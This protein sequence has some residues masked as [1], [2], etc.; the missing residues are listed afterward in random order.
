MQLYGC[1]IYAA[2]R[3]HVKPSGRRVRDAG[4][5]A[6]GAKL[7]AADDWIRQAH[8]D[9]EGFWE[10][11]AFRLYEA[12][13]IVVRPG[14]RLELDEQPY[15]EVWLIRAGQ[16][17]IQLRGQRVVAGPGEVAV[18]R[19]GGHRVSANEGGEPLALVGFGFSVMMF[20]AVDLLPRLELPLV[21]SDPSGR[22]R[23][24]V[25]SVV[26]ATNGTRTDR[27]FR[28]RGQAEL[29]FAEIIGLAGID[30]PA[31]ASTEALRDEVEAALAYIAEHYPDR[32]DVTTL[33]SA[34]HLSPKY[35][36][37]CFREALGI[38]PMA[39]VRRY[40]L[41][42]AREQLVT[43][44]LPITRIAHD[45]GFQDAAHFS[46]AFR[47]LYGVSARILREHAR[48]LRSN[49]EY[50]GTSFPDSTTVT[51]GYQDT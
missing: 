41:E 14:W 7:P 20:E 39:Y 18:L 15:G 42:R 32:L 40:R 49:A 26:R 21:L 36:A 22:L 34:V 8:V 51:S 48:A 29:A 9:L 37:R 44:D 28:A 31:S 19:P 6:T 33:A 5:M 43:S 50:S 45:T 46:R 47:T 25:G 10:A 11:A 38:T 4:R 2:N 1:L 35:L 17:T 30:L 12:Y 24:L 16:C 27:V 23:R 13:D 3:L